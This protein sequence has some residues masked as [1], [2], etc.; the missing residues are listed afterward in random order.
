MARRSKPLGPSLGWQ[1]A[2]WADTFLC[3][4]PGDL[5]GDPFVTDPEMMAFDAR[6]YELEPKTGRRLIDEA[7]LSRCKGRAKS[8][9]AG[10]LVCVEA[11]GPARFDHWAIKG[12]TSW[13]GYA[14]EPGEP[15]GRPV[16]DP[17]IRCLATEESQAGNTYDNVFVMLSH[18][19]EKFG[20]DFPR[21]DI[22]LTRVFI[23]GG[24]EIRPST[25]SSAAKDGGKETFA[26]ADETHLYTLAELHDMYDTVS[27]NLTKRPAAEP[28][29]LNTSTMFQ[30]GKD[31]EAERLHKRSK[32]G[33]DPRLLLDHLE[34]AEPKDWESDEELTA[35]LRKAAGSGAEWMD[36][37]RRLRECRRTSKAKACRYFLNL[38]MVDE[39]HA[40]DPKR[41]D[42]LAVP[43]GP[44]PEGTTIAIG[45]DGSESGD[46]TGLIGCVMETGYQFVIG[47]WERPEKVDEWQVPR[48]QV[49][50]VVEQ[51]FTH[52]VVSRMYCDPKGWRSEIASWQAR[53]TDDV[54]VPYPTNSWRRF[55]FA[56]D[57]FLTAVGKG[58]VKGTL[59]HDGDVTFAKHVANAHKLEINPRKPEDGVILV[60]A[61]P[62]SSLKID[63]AVAACLAGQARDDT[64]SAGWVPRRQIEPMVT[65]A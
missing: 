19:S 5:R 21:L 4:G 22:G 34:A 15:V 49:D 51:A 17:F 13:W 3:H 32:A 35:A 8:E 12:E 30:P 28:W 57:R 1:I 46:S 2:D 48:L 60:K 42:E 45:F 38:S 11:I 56:V 23:A 16:R 20:G 55:G 53:W 31:S 59:T 58:T 52:Y 64:L 7:M 62:N 47:V 40:V 14:F 26:V 25:A 29:L 65:W 9:E 24:G 18:L 39:E 41:W 43:G 54:V 50:A 44:P 36:F 6:C 37:V 33:D 27:R 10:K 63:L 61:S